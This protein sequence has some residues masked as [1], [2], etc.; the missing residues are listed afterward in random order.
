[1]VNARGL[2]RLGMLAVGL[3]IGATVAS[4]VVSGIDNLNPGNFDLG[5]ILFQDGVT[6]TGA[7]GADYLY[8]IV[9]A[10]GTETNAAAATAGG[11]LADLLALF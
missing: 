3:G 9:T 8:D 2:A 7:S 10:L 11:W 4:T 5:A 6:N 1:M